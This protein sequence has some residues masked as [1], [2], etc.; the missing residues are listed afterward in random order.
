MKENPHR[1]FTLLS[2]EVEV[3]EPRKERKKIDPAKFAGNKLIHN[4]DPR[5]KLSGGPRK[6][7][8]DEL[9]K[10]AL[11]K[12]QKNGRS[13]AENIVNTMIDKAIEGN[14]SMVK[15]IAERVGG[16]ATQRVESDGEIRVT[17]ER[18]G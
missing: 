18:I 17:V 4:G 11:A 15:L 9:L 1:E 14:V 6:T 10:K 2:N 3:L 7:M 12:T 16:L 5:H 8:L 13:A